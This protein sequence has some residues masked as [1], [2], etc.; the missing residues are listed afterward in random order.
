MNSVQIR[1]YDLFRKEL[2][3]PDD[4]AAALVSAVGEV[5]EQEF[6]NEKQTPLTKDDIQTVKEDIQSVKEDIL[7]IKDSI[8]VLELKVEQTKGDI[9]KA[10]FWTGILQLLSILGGVLVIL[11]FIH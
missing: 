3:L 6:K 2:N 10:I 9:Y 11:K 1:L 8:H 5:V 4:K 7:T